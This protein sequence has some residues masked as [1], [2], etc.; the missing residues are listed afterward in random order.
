MVAHETRS[1]F[2]GVETHVLRDALSDG[3]PDGIRLQHERAVPREGEV[4]GAEQRMGWTVVDHLSF[5]IAAEGKRIGN[6]VAESARRQGL[7][8]PWNII[9]LKRR[10]HAAIMP[11]S[12]TGHECSGHGAKGPR[13]GIRVYSVALTGPRIQSVMQ[14]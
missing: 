3:E 10:R 14:E 11:R 13:H 7:P 2:F 8:R 5:G 12:P 6:C 9:H 1:Q 4:D